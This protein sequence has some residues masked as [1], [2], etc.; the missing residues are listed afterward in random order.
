MTGRTLQKGFNQYFQQTPLEY[1][2]DLRV[3]LV[4]QTLLNSHENETVTDIVLRHGFQSLGHF[5]TLYKKR[6]GC[7]PSKTLK[8]SP[9]QMSTMLS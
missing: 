9:V 7:L 1:I 6:Y 2:R 8:M 5:S 3:E 4:H